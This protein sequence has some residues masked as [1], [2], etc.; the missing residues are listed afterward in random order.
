PGGVPTRRGGAGESC[1]ARPAATL[2]AREQPAADPR[3][4]GLA[5]DPASA[6][7]RFVYLYYSYA[8]PGGATLNRL[9]RMHHT[10][11]SGTDE[12][13]LLDNIPG[14]S[15]HDGGRIALGPA[16]KLYVAT[17]DGEQQAPAQDP[18]SLG[19]KNVLL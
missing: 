16:A 17:G 3:L 14:S 4:L 6:R 9:V 8:A 11:G 18:S 1:E 12:P 7:T 5:R 13:I 10:S 15:N 2:P 19:R